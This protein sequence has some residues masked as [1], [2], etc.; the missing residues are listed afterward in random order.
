MR[1]HPRHVASQLILGDLRAVELP[2]AKRLDEIR[3]IGSS[4]SNSEIAH[5]LDQT[6]LEVIGRYRHESCGL[7]FASVCHFES[8]FPV[9]S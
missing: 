6:A 5:F 7:K 2:S 3:E 8:P 9:V 4:Q 1:F